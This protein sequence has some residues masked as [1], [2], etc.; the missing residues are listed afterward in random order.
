MRRRCLHVALIEI[1]L[2]CC[3]SAANTFE[4]LHGLDMHQGILAGPTFTMRV[5]SGLMRRECLLSILFVALNIGRQSHGLNVASPVFCSRLFHGHLAE[6]SGDARI[7]PATDAKHISLTA[8]VAQER[9]EV[10]NTCV[11]GGF[12]VKL[13]GWNHTVEE[14]DFLS[15]FLNGNE[16]CAYSYLYNCI[17]ARFGIVC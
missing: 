17:V 8:C 4:L 16:A 1:L 7:H 15:N 3:L 9:F 2:S 12:W 6:F 13:F 11:H 14:S 10:G 5:T